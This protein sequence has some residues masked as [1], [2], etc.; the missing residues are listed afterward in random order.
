[1]AINFNTADL[2]GAAFDG[3]QCTAC[4]FSGTKLSGA[5][6]SNASMLATNF[7]G[8]TGTLADKELRSL[9]SGC[10][11]CNFSG[12]DL[13]RRDLSQTTL[14]SVDLSRANLANT[15]FDGAVLCWEILAQSRRQT[16]CDRMAN[17]QTSG[18]SFAGVLACD[19]P[20]KR[21]GCA[22]VDAR[23]LREKVGSSLQGA[24]LP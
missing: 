3:A 9:L 16:Q 13:A 17:A 23:T 2:E 1:M 15:R 18:A 12:V 14:I 5:T 4:N 11:S 21:R 6:F 10:V 20:L 7:E 19:D 8:F 22:R 24:I